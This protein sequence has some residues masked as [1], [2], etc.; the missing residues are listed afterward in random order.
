MYW[1]HKLKSFFPCEPSPPKPELRKM[2]NWYPQ[3][4]LL[5]RDDLWYVLTAAERSSA[6]IKKILKCVMHFGA[7]ELWSLGLADMEIERD[8][9]PTFKANTSI[10]LVHCRY[11]CT[12]DAEKRYRPLAVLYDIRVHV[13]LF[14]WATANVISHISRWDCL[15][16]P[17]LAYLQF[18]NLT[19]LEKRFKYY[20]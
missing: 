17:N 3:I 7:I 15:I 8:N 16:Q 6:S 13:F 11:K 20:C 2:K 9:W 5:V 18:F 14:L 12:A 1:W 19:H 10:W 4:L